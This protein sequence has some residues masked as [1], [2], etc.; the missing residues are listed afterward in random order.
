MEKD[1][2]KYFL[3]LEPFNGGRITEGIFKY[4]GALMKEYIKRDKILPLPL[5]LA[6]RNHQ[7]FIRKLMGDWGEELA[8]ASD[9]YHVKVLELFTGSIY[10]DQKVQKDLKALLL[11][12]TQE[13]I[14]ALHFMVEICIYLNIDHDDIIGLLKQS[15]SEQNLPLA[16]EDALTTSLWYGRYQNNERDENR[17]YRKEGFNLPFSEPTKIAGLSISLPMIEHSKV[18]FWE[19]TQAM[20]IA[21]NL[22]KIKDTRESEIQTNINTLQ[23]KV[24][25]AWVR[26]MQLLDF[27][28]LDD[29]KDIYIHYENKNL[30]NQKRIIEGY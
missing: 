14:D 2:S 8:E 10:T 19:A 6:D 30:I 7:N 23:V 12:F 26:F 11:D 15:L 13:L 5:N 4:Q 25:E 3:K 22:M 21:R 9:V 27:L 29:P 20:F 17:I 24:V 18:M 16:T 1:D 28:G